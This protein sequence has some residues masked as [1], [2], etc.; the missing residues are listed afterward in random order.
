MNKISSFTSQHFYLEQLAEGVYAAINSEEGWA[1]CNAGIIDLGDRTLVYDAF[2][3]PQAAEDLRKAAEFLTNRPVSL[4]VDSHYHN[5]HIWGNQSFDPET[6]IISTIKTRELII[7]EG[8]SEIKWNRE[9][10]SVRLAQLEAQ[11]AATS[12]ENV[13]HHLRPLIADFKANVAALPILQIRLPNLTFSEEMV[14]HGSQRTARL[15]P[16]D[17]AHCGNDVILHLPDDGIAFLED[18]LFIDCHPYLGDGDPD[19]IQSVLAQVRQ[20]QPSIVVPGHGPVGG[21]EH[22]DV[23]DGYINRLKSIA[24]D[25]FSRGLTEEELG[26]V[27]IPEEYKHFLFSVF[28]GVNLKFLYQR[29]LKK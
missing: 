1:I 28:F 15:I 24:A 17:N 10:A 3:T 23:L 19:V 6:D 13:R 14:L 27:P 9:T 16:F 25:A 2:N 29:Q 5:D 22:L 26:Q 11:Y 4:L 8:P 21:P 20:M 18:I 12:D 7:T